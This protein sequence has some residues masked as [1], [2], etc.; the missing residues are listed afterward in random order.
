MISNAIFFTQVS[1]MAP[2][3]STRSGSRSRSTRSGNRSSNATGTAA[4]LPG[5]TTNRNANPNANTN[6][7]DNNNAG[8]NANN[9]NENEASPYENDP[10]YE[11]WMGILACG[12]NDV[13]LAKR[14]SMNLFMDD[15]EQAFLVK[16]EDVNAAFKTLERQS[17]AT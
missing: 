3:R 17:E 5:R 8:R 11:L 12:I 4:A 9:D 10:P 7:N 13:A 15:F 14:L 16:T 1:T 6:N 2:T